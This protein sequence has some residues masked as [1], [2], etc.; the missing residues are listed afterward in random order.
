[1]H[2]PCVTYCC[3]VHRI[4]TQRCKRRDLLS[5]RS[6]PGNKRLLLPR[7]CIKHSSPS[8]FLASPHTRSH[9]P[10][11]QFRLQALN[12]QIFKT[13]SIYSTFQDH[14]L[15]NQHHEPPPPLPS[16]PGLPHPR[17]SPGPFQRQCHHHLPRSRRR[18]RRMPAPIR[19]LSH[20]KHLLRTALLR[21]ELRVSG[22][23]LIV[24]TNRT[25][26][27]GSQ[28]QIA[29]S[30]VARTCVASTSS[31]ITSA[32]LIARSFLHAAWEARGSGCG[33]DEAQHTDMNFTL[34]R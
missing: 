26:G 14:T 28:A 3:S 16:L 21:V 34:R 27:A 13:T 4:F 8:S 15:H 11:L 5:T 17:Q 7:M 9:Q 29:N 31:V 33:K 12:H 23:R 32:G 1:M 19:A 25:H 30:R 2:Y 20:G 22:T 10:Q 18:L 6:V 24:N